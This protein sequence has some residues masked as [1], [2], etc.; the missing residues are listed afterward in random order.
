MKLRDFNIEIYVAFFDLSVPVEEVLRF[1]PKNPYSAANRGEKKQEPAVPRGN[2]VVYRSFAG[3]WNGNFEE[4]WDNLKQVFFGYEQG[5][6]AASKLAQRV[7]LQIIIDL[8]SQ[9]LPPLVMP[10][11]MIAFAASLGASIEFD[12]IFS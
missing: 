12:M 8:D 5:L 10:S 2:L 7:T 4:H 6:I 11:E 1:M 3:D 9:R